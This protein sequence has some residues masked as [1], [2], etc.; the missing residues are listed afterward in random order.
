MFGRNCLLSS[1]LLSGYNML[2][3]TRFSRGMTRLMGWRGGVCHSCP[4]AIPCSLSSL[5]SRIHSSLF[6]DWR[7]IV[8]SKFFDTQVS[9]FLLRSL[10]FLS[11]SLCPL[12]SS[13][14]RTQPSVT[15][16]S[17]Y[18]RQKQKS[19]MQRLWTVVPGHLS[20]HSAL[21]SFGVLTPLALW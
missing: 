11:R 8:S 12:W 1:P 18:N 4:L 5:T 17:P 13:L 15:L 21:S 20:S 6:S 9:W 3:D 16:L 7:R 2:P 19:L 10:C 14:Q